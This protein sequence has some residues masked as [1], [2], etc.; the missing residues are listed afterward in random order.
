[1]Q[2]VQ[3]SK[4]IQ[5]WRSYLLC[6]LK[7]IWGTEWTSGIKCKP[8]QSHRVIQE[9]DGS[10]T[11][12]RLSCKSWIQMFMWSS[13][14]LYWWLT[15]LFCFVFTL[16]RWK[17][18]HCP[19]KLFLSQLLYLLVCLLLLKA[20]QPKYQNGRMRTGK[21][22]ATNIHTHTKKKTCCHTKTPTQLPQN[23]MTT[24]NEFQKEKEKKILPRSL[25]PETSPGGE[26]VLIIRCCV[27]GLTT[28]PRRLRR[29]KG[30]DILPSDAKAWSGSPHTTLSNS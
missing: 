28:M 9:A 14:L 2:Q 17:H 29:E 19:M 22:T 20:W 18:P 11:K 7:V 3:V 25:E 5:V 21:R 13:T 15:F 10:R 12:L 26:D 6:N 1:M 30:Q 24:N 27:C 16:G 8:T 4:Q 23:S